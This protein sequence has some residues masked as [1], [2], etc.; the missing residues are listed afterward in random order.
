[1]TSDEALKKQTDLAQHYDL[2]WWYGVNCA[3]CCGVYPRYITEANGGR[4]YECDVCGKTTEPKA[5]PKDA[6]EAWNNGEFIEGQVRM[7]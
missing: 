1:M 7:F 3:K 6:E 5:M 2:R 4:R